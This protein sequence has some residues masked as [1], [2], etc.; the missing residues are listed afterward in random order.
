M[1][2]CHNTPGKAFWLARCAAGATKE[3]VSGTT[4]SASVRTNGGHRAPNYYLLLGGEHTGELGGGEV[5]DGGFILREA[6][7]GDG[8]DGA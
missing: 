6:V 2:Q 7:K 1:L 3:K 8:E 5:T 4:D